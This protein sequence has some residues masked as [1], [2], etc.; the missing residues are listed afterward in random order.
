MNIVIVIRSVL[1]V[2]R[3]S[4]EIE[5]SV[6]DLGLAH[7]VVVAMREGCCAFVTFSLFYGKVV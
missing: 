6:E 2:D 3:K 1:S 7:E 4:R 5:I